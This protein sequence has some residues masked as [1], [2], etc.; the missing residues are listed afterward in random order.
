MIICCC[1][2]RIEPLYLI[3]DSKSAVSLGHAKQDGP[4]YCFSDIDST[5]IPKIQAWCRQIGNTH[6]KTSW[7]ATMEQLLKLAAEIHA[8]VR[9]VNMDDVVQDDVEAMKST[10]QSGKSLKVGIANRL[11]QVRR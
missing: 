6:R 8:Y 3:H 2:V 7:F 5:G 11:R 4:A 1:G 10:W 9:H